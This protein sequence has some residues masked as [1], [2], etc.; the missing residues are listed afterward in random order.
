MI[1]DREVAD[2]ETKKGG[3]KLQAL[4][5]AVAAALFLLG[6]QAIEPYFF[7]RDDNASH[8]LP[9][10][11][12]AFESLVDDGE[13]PWVNQHQSLGGT[14][15][16]PGQTGVFL[17][18]LY[19]VMGAL[20]LLAFDPIL[21]IDFLAS[22]HL[23]LAALGMWW[24]LRYR[25]VAPALAF[26]LA[27]TWAL[28]PFG[29][30]LGR[31]WVFVTYLMAYLPWHFL[32]LL[33]FLE[34]PS[35]RLFT[36]LVV[37]KVVFLFTGYPHYLLL[38][39]FF[40]AVF[41]GLA[42]LFC[43]PETRTFLRR[44]LAAVLSTSLLAALAAAPLLLPLL[45]AKAESVERAGGLPAALALDFSLPPFE[46]LFSQLLW[47]KPAWLL[48][49]GSTFTFYF[50]LPLILATGFAVRGRRE[51]GLWTRA[52]AVTG[53]LALLFST[54]L[55]WLLLQ[56]PVFASLRWPFKGFPIA[57]FFLFL[58]AAQGAELW[59]A[60]GSFGRE[61]SRQR[62]VLA[63]FWLNLLVQFCG[64]IPA[65]WRAPLSATR[66]DRPVTALRSA[67]PLK[68]IEKSG[69]VAFLRAPNDEPSD[70][71]PL[72]L[73]FLYATL[74]DRYQVQGYD[75]LLARTNSELTFRTHI[76]GEISVTPFSW[77]AIREKLDRCSAR[78]LLLAEKSSLVPF[79]LAS[80][81]IRLLGRDSG[82]VLL[83]DQQARPIVAL[84]PNGVALPFTWRRNGIAVDLAADFP[85]GRISFNIAPLDHYRWLREGRLQ[86]PPS[87]A[88][89]RPQIELPP[90][91]ARIELRYVEPT[92]WWGLS[93]ALAAVLLLFLGHRYERVLLPKLEPEGAS[94]S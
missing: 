24:L 80:P 8:F 42:A 76:D 66:L 81:G 22:L 38:A 50:G 94:F 83:E 84:E 41:L 52:A 57:T 37:V 32:L 31:S 54:R 60:K 64:F 69:R 30:V 82:L 90:G 92:R 13:I 47:P 33:R 59:I 73:G 68:L 44:R 49:A 39:L 40:E 48:G 15:L 89:H 25:K 61:I 70:A 75:P 88:E 1:P 19:P 87:L 23:V 74:T 86:G 34:K 4:L 63:A 58:V 28:L 5:V 71:S 53:L 55:Y 11:L 62:L 93:A 3:E 46:F 14:F 12:H 78:Y 18:L 91:P 67:S 72:R 36:A 85:G 45:R 26:V 17:A 20:R 35:A 43:P 21:L 56:L 51:I 27:L 9:A 79:L 16:A 65:A 29:V 6:L 10:Y 2:A 7:L 77:P